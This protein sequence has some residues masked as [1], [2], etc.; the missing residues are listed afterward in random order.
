MKMIYQVNLSGIWEKY[1]KKMSFPSFKYSLFNAEE[2]EK[3][4]HKTLFEK[5]IYTSGV[6]VGLN[7]ALNIETIMSQYKLILSSFE[8][9][10][11]QQ[12]NHVST[13]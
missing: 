8:S 6:E 11:N 4:Q 1:Y 13:M 2:R 3:L 10:V 9:F 7:K 5:F 12:K